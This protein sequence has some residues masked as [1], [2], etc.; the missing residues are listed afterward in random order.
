[1][2]PH[3]KHGTGRFHWN[4]GGW[5]GGQVGATLWLVLLGC[6]LM[7]QGRKVGAVVLVLGLVP[8]FV[9][10]ALWR[11][12][13]RLSPYPALQLLIAT[14]GISAL[15]SMVVLWR[16]TGPVSSLQLPSS[17]WFLLLYPGLMLVFHLQERAARKAAA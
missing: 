1:M 5:F 4:R 8:N 3:E 2:H 15:V 7:A 9:G 11:H 16:L 12:R 17:L 13:H 6:L 10:L 14:A